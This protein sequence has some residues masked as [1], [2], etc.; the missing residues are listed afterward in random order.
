[1]VRAPLGGESDPVAAPSERFA[2]DLLAPAAAVAVGC[3]DIVDAP[4]DRVADDLRIADRV[5]SEADLGDLEAGPAENALTHRRARV[6]RGAGRR[7]RSAGGE[8]AR[9]QGAPGD[10]RPLQERAPAE[11]APGPVTGSAAG[12]GHPFFPRRTIIS[13][14]KNART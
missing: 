4:I 2:D 14:M 10:G 13:A 1:M 7:E 5:A 3:I 6:G 12:A 9:D 8:R 11:S